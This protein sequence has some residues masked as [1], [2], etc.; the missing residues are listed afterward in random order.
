MRSNFDYSLEH[1]I[2]RDLVS[3][4]NENLWK[5]S[6]VVDVEK[7]IATMTTI[8]RE[9]GLDEQDFHC[10]MCR[11]SI[12]GTFSKY[13]VC[14]I[15]GLYYCSDCMRA[16]GELPIPSRILRSWDW[17]LRPVSDRGRAFFEANQGLRE[18]LQIV[19]MYL[20]NC[21]ESIADDFRKR[22]WP[23]DHLYSDIHA[24]SVSD[25]ILVRS[26]LLEKQIMGFL[27]HAIDHVMRCFLCRQ[28]G[29]VCEV[30]ESSEII[31]P[32]Q[33]ETTRKCSHCYSVFH[34]TIEKKNRPYCLMTSS[35]F[36]ETL[37]CASWI[38]EE[39]IEISSYK[40]Y[41][42]Y[43]MAADDIAIF[44]T[45]S[46]RHRQIFPESAQ[47]L[48]LEKFVKTKNLVPDRRTEKTKKKTMKIKIDPDDIV[49][50]HGFGRHDVK[51]VLISVMPLN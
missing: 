39:F 45:F 8:P 24:Y 2:D 25:L 41:Y 7:V 29:F 15:D 22:V 48:V 28:K 37:L 38:E 9:V 44:D 16:G 1:V 19:S 36:D 43:E 42:V 33:T 4:A 30:C 6:A 40:S 47:Q 46:S 20:F 5:K 32:F 49:M 23:R 26:G 50:E 34:T 11:K 51:T 21:R 3:D 10:P 18:K 13:G 12:G 31:Y 17:K 27:K 35:A 14:G